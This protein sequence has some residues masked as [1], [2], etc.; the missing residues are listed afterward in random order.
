ML[1]QDNQ[2]LKNLWNGALSLT[3]RARAEGWCWQL[4]AV[5][6]TIG[7][8]SSSSRVVAQDADKPA[9]K[10][11]KFKTD[12]G[13]RSGVGEAILELKGGAMLLQTP[14]GQLWTLYPEEI[15]SSEPTEEEM[16]PLTADEVFD[17][18]SETLPPG[19]RVYKTKHYVLVH[20]TDDAYVKWVGS[21][22]EDLHRGFLN[23]WKQ[24]GLKLE[25]PRFPLVAVVF[26][27][28]PSYLTY[29]QREMGEAAKSMIGYYNLKTNRITT[30]DLTG[31][32][33]S[34]SGKQRSSAYIRQILSRPEAERTVATIVHEAVHQLAFNCGLQVRL[35]DNP[36]W[37]SEGL[38]MFFESPDAS[39]SARGWGRIGK[40]NQ[41]NFKLFAQYVRARPR[42]SLVTLI[43]ND[44]RFK[45]T[46]T[47]AQAYPESWA[48]TYFLIKT[49]EKDYVKY[50]QELATQQPLN[51]M[52]DKER[53]NLFKKHF[54]EDLSKLDRAFISYMRRIAR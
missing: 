6:T 46:A 15:I 17:Q 21:L 26:G 42:D 50:I 29:A 25:E 39:P 31:V 12:A 4:L 22:F 8:F 5:L 54:G 13:V 43:T 40:I 37:M 34:A 41:H 28:K 33:G 32:S 11:I 35:A 45:K 51:E 3:F 16:R 23:F 30:Y 47:A 7:C 2:N 36:L 27:D 10:Q 19:F 48:L 44:E 18:F 38:A 9:T 24:R 14:D 52:S 53:L 1:L 49:R 20:N